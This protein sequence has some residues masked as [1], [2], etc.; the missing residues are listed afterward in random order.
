M[1]RGQPGIGGFRHRSVRWRTM[2][3]ARFS[4]RSVALPEQSYGRHPDL[5]QQC[6]SI[7]GDVRRPCR[8]PV[9]I[10]RRSRRRMGAGR[11]RRDR[12]LYAEK[13]PRRAG[14]GCLLEQDRLPPAAGRSVPAGRQSARQRDLA[15]AALSAG[16]RCCQQC[17][18]KDS[19]AAGAG[20]RAIGAGAARHHRRD[21]L[22]ALPVASGARCRR[23]LRPRHDRA[24]GQAGSETHCRVPAAAGAV[25]Q[26][27]PVAVPRRNDA[28]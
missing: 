14:G 9:R 4:G 8:D 3:N 20:H 10:L 23:P 12:L 11:S 19:R 15:T 16:V 7:L 25:R 24:V 6:Q 17:L 21:P 28:G 2:G 22:R 13:I 18:Q 27:M 26:P 5:L 1:R